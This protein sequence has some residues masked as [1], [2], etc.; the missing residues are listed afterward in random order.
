MAQNSAPLLSQ[1]DE[2]NRTPLGTAFEQFK[3][4]L[5]GMEKIALADVTLKDVLANVQ[6]LDRQHAMSSKSRNLIRRLEPFLGFLDRHAKAL[7]SIAQV[8]PNPSALIWGLVRVLLETALAYSQYFKKLVA[9]TE[10]LSD[11]LTLY[12]EY[13]G[14]LNGDRR[15]QEAL[16]TVYF[17]VLVFLKKATIIFKTRG[18]QILCRSLWRTFESDFQDTLEAI[19]RHTRSLETEIDLAYRIDV[20]RRLEKHSKE[21][22]AIHGS[23]SRIECSLH[24][25]WKV[26]KWLSPIDMEGIRNRESRRRTESSG[27]WL[28]QDEFFQ[29]WLQSKHRALWI[30]GP[31][32]SGK[33]VLSAFIVDTIRDR[34]E[35]E[36][37]QALAF[38]FCDRGNEENASTLKIL[39]SM[40]AQVLGQLCS[41]PDSICASYNIASRYGRSKV[42][43]ADQ[44]AIIM[45]DL[46]LSLN[47]LY[48]LVD[49]IDELSSA[50]DVLGTMKALA[51]ST[52]MIQVIFLSRDSPQLSNGLNGIPKINLT[53]AVVSS[54]IN[55]YISHELAGLSLRNT[56]LKDQIFERLSQGANGMFLWA[57]LMIKTLKSSVSPHEIMEALSDLPVD[58]DTTYNAILNKIAREPPNRQALAKKVLQWI[59]CSVRPLHWNELECALSFERSHGNFVESKKPFKSVVLELGS[60]LVEY[61]PSSDLFRLTHHSVREFLLSSPDDHL[62]HEDARKFFILEEL[63]NCE[64]AE[65]CLAYQIRHGSHEQ[66]QVHTAPLPLLEY[67]TLFWCHHICNAFCSQE[68]ERLALEFLTPQSRRRIWVLRFIYW[69]SSTFPLQYLMKS[70]KFLRDWISQGTNHHLRNTVTNWIQDVPFI[71][72]GHST[73]APVEEQTPNVIN[74]LHLSNSMPEIPYFEKLMIIRD[75]SREY[76]MTGTLASGEEWLTTALNFQR[77]RHGTSHISTVWLMNSLGIIYDQQQRVVL[78]AHTQESAL[79]IQT[80]VLGPSHLETVWTVNELGRIYRHLGDFDRA[81]SMHKRALIALRKV[82]HP[83]DLQIAWTLNTLART[84]R[85]QARFAEAI[86]LHDQALAIQRAILGE[87]HPHTLWATMDKAGCYRGQG[88][89]KESA[90]LYQN[91]LD[92]RQKVLGLKHPDTLW[93]MNDLALVLAELGQIGAAKSLQEMTLSG[94][95]EVLGLGH[96]HTLWTKGILNELNARASVLDLTLSDN[97]VV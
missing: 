65:V 44:P 26:M 34:I 16:A 36:A 23:L 11:S 56:E 3:R 86:A 59:C 58:L 79:A 80:S 29:D 96:K 82:L 41:I 66:R 76:T 64:L 13:E 25:R 88:R 57:H 27:Q 33:T 32:G 15:F 2:D 60:P 6:D 73:P 45:K 38:F 95:T 67:S 1:C 83:Q 19:T 22:D 21:H 94:Q 40:I 35:S 87:S 31:P 51:D 49:G 89:L 55:N 18:F 42:S 14:I 4:T 7:D 97:S 75:L 12:Q 54:D 85:K 92:W 77:A 17:D 84:Y 68:L 28:L 62:V 43:A 93:A 91:A 50:S 47:K 8:H 9:M 52:T 74:G 24:E 5:N 48:I 53:S 39:A 90:V 69:Q 46:A 71:L 78:S 20:R 81:E 70:Q 63:G 72:C 37:K 10:R 30:S 61:I